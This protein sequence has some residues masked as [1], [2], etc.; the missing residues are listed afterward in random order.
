MKD[1]AKDRRKARM[2]RKVAIRKY[3]SGTAERP[4]LTV[5][6]SHRA[7][8]V[9]VI[10]DVAGRTVASADSFKAAAI[11]VPKEFTG[12]CAMAYTV[13][14]AIAETAKS[15]GIEKI[16]FDRNGYLYHGRIAALAKGARDGGLDF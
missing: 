9:Q 13:G 6:R 16:V 4:R 15:N 14:R 3:L 10:D 8:Y 7:I 2:R 1:V 12:K 11:E 5:K